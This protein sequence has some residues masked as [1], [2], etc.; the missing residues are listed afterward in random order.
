[1]NW[2]APPQSLTLP[3]DEVHIWKAPLHSAPLYTQ[4]LS[5]DEQERANRFL[6]EKHRH[7]FINARGILRTI[8]GNYLGSS[9]KE[10]R[11]QVQQGGKPELQKEDETRTRLRF[12][13]AHTGD[14]AIYAVALDDEIGIDL[15]RVHAYCEALPIANRFFSKQEFDWLQAQPLEERNLSFFRLWTRKEAYLKASGDG[16]RRPL[17]QFTILPDQS[18]AGDL[19]IAELEP[20]KD[21]V[22]VLMGYGCRKRLVTYSYPRCDL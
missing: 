10:L 1:M 8:L 17:N 20:E 11:F 14:L 5:A 21:H 4:L 15:E 18:S 12:N 19:W 6:F 7:R 3:T 13:L 16:L 22:A 9:P 2:Q